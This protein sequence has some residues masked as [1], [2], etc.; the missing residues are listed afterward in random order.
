MITGKTAVITGGNRG[1]GR[2]IAERLA[3][4]GARVVICARDQAALDETVAA[5]EQ[6]GGSASAIALDLRVPDAAAALVAHTGQ[7]DIVVN[8][9]GD[10]R[11]GSFLSLSDQDWMDSFSLKLFAAVRLTRLAWPELKRRGGAVVN[12]AGVGG[13][14]PGAQ[15]AVGGSVNAAMLSFTKALAELG[16]ADGVQVNAVNPGPIRTGRFDRRIA[17]EAAQSGLSIAEATEA[18]VR[19][20]GITQLGEPAD[21][22][23]LV[24]FL[25]GPEGRLI[26]GTFIDIDGGSTKTL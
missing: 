2:A 6:A 4:D 8:N 1:I 12:I 17:V 11:R 18:F 13:R 15:F 9:A 19:R 20:E 3:R 5:I 14:T 24:A 22:A 7:I 26:H 16:R 10:T 23:N 25:V 21:V